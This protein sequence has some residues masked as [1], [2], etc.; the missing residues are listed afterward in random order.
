MA[1]V[2]GG[3]YALALFV[4]VGVF[5]DENYNR[6]CVNAME[7]TG[8]YRAGTQ[9]GDRFFSQNWQKPSVKMEFHCQIETQI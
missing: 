9:R 3:K 7:E 2:R 4:T 6:S 5:I 1:C 8:I